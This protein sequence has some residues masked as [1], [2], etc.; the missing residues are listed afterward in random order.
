ML[1]YL[2]FLLEDYDGIEPDMKIGRII[3]IRDEDSAEFIINLIL[4]TELKA[5]IVNIPNYKLEKIKDLNTILDVVSLD[6]NLTGFYNNVQDQ[7]LH[8]VCNTHYNPIWRVA[9]YFCDFLTRANRNYN[10]NK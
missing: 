5:Y 10:D 2:E 4:D 8:G 9:A 3:G 6:K 1:N 7:T